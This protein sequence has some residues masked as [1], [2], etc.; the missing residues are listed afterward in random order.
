MFRRNSLACRVIPAHTGSRTYGPS[1]LIALIPWRR[2][3]NATKTVLILSD[4]TEPRALFGDDS[5]LV[6]QA[7]RLGAAALFAIAVTLAAPA[8]SAG[9]PVAGASSFATYCGN[10]HVATSRLL[11]HGG[12]GIEVIEQHLVDLSERGIYLRVAGEHL[13]D[14]AAY[15]ATLHNY[16][17]LWWNAPAGSESGWGL[18][19]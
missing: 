6:R 16:S 8:H 7:A 1:L 10:C 18:N 19:L 17:G 15:L 5:G 13:E 3:M 4:S 11:T 9:D 12:G 14:I 2:L